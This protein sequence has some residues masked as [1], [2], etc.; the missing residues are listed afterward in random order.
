WQDKLVVSA[1]SS[2]KQFIITPESL[3]VETIDLEPGRI[4]GFSGII[5]EDDKIWLLPIQGQEIW[6]WE[7]RNGNVN[8]YAGFPEGFTCKHPGM[9]FECD[10]MPLNSVAFTEDA[11]YI[12]PNWGNKFLKLDRESGKITEWKNNF[13]PSPEAANGYLYTWAIGWFCWQGW[14]QIT[15]SLPKFMYSPTRTLYQVDWQREQWEKV[16]VSFDD[17]SK[18]H[19]SI[20]FDRMSK[21]FLYGCNENAFNSLK[22][23]LDG[24]I[25]G[26]AFDKEKQLKAYEDI[27][28]NNDGT[29]GEKIFAYVRRK[30][31]I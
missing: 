14:E 15:K 16:P 9:H 30:L 13:K 21:W 20:G 5:P 28:V 29:A 1:A 25:Q 19:M 22:D 24:N 18:E 26:K 11:V 31:G 10:L 23:L 27:A 7:P 4:S 12:T 17:D 8:K 3:A 6:C 2:A